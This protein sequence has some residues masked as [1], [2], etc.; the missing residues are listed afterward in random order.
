MFSFLSL[1]SQRGILETLTNHHP[2]QETPSCQVNKLLGLF[3]YLGRCSD[4][5][6]SQQGSKINRWPSSWNSSQLGTQASAEWITWYKNRTICSHWLSEKGGGRRASFPRFPS[7][8]SWSLSIPYHTCHPPTWD[9]HPCVHPHFSL[10]LSSLRCKS[11][12][13]SSSTSRDSQYPFKTLGSAAR[14]L[15]PSALGTWVHLL[16]NG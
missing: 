1:P 13:F 6:G 4:E 5:G 15:T 8:V 3:P 16:I 7:R 11:C 10:S 2:P 9:T 12:G 14:S